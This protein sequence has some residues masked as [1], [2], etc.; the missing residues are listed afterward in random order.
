MSE[1]SSQGELRLTNG[2]TSIPRAG[3]RAEDSTREKKWRFWEPPGALYI[4]SSAFK[5]QT[6][7]LVTRG[8][9]CPPKGRPRP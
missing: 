8:L 2:G 7:A 4:W 6:R 1:L 5:A 9:R 3:R